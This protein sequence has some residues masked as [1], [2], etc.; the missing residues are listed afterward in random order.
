MT[1]TKAA[2]KRGSRRTTGCMPK[3]PAKMATKDK[4]NGVYDVR[5]KIA[6]V[7]VGVHGD[8]NIGAVARAMKNF[9]LS[10]LR[11]VDAVPHRTKTAYMWAVD[12]KDV[13][14][15][16]HSFATL[17]DALADVSTAVAFTRRLGKLRKKHMTIHEA[18]PWIAERTSLG[19]V[20][21]VFGREDKGLSNDEICRCDSLV[22]IPSASKFPSLNLAQAVIIAG[23][24]IFCSIQS[25]SSLASNLTHHTREDPKEK[26]VSRH[27]VAP[28]LKR[29]NLMLEALGYKDLPG[30][31]LKSKIL[32]QL[33]RIFGRAG[34]TVKDL[35]M[36]EGLIARIK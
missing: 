28:V 32:H 17:D 4:D 3:G 19:P 11:L 30:A 23:Y 27:E 25:S 21:L 13:L 20:A 35:K 16:A 29:L 18:A 33:E 5:Y 34:L 10:N 2:D 8:A 36:W 22:T 12:A 31:P 6:I 9:G 15:N 1:L 14:D 26:F 24:E 7:L